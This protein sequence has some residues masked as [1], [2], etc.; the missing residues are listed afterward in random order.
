MMRAPVIEWSVGS[1]PDGIH[2]TARTGRGVH[3]LGLTHDDAR[4]LV[5]KLSEELARAERVAPGTRRTAP[6]AVAVTDEEPRA[7][8]AGR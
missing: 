1:S 8:R 6:P 2:V 5:A 3:V 7:R 4:W